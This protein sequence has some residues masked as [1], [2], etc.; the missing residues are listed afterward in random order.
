[1]RWAILCG[2]VACDHGEARRALPPPEP[3]LVEGAAPPAPDAGPA[4]AGE[5]PLAGLLSDA[6][7][8]AR[9]ATP[10]GVGRA[11][12]DPLRVI[13]APDV[14]VVEW[15]LSGEAAGGAWVSIRG[16]TFLARA[17]G[18]A[19]R[20]YA[21]GD[22]ARA[23][24]A[25]GPARPR[26]PEIARDVAPPRAERVVDDGP[27]S[28]RDDANVAAVRAMLSAVDA[29]RED[30]WTAAQHDDVVWV[31][32]TQTVPSRGLGESRRFFR[33]LVASMPDVRVEVAAIRGIGGRWVIAELVTR[34]TPRRARGARS[35]HGGM[36]RATLDVLELEDGRVRR[37]WVY[38]TRAPTPAQGA[39]SSNQ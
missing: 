27:P 25:A 19:A 24:I 38:G 23:Q 31:D 13:A 18:G 21:D 26:P 20:T 1:M 3:R 34:G 37:G 28:P 14:G 2:I 35:P 39:P 4:D 6:E 33:A 17:D 8:A 22:T 5:D 32:A 7:R 36:T 30:G 29:H 15:A 12:V 11:R 10:A 9:A 16:A